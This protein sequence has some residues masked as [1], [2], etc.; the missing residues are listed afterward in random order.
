MNRAFILL[1]M[2]LL[3]AALHA[4]PE[5]VPDSEVYGDA[6]P[7]ASALPLSRAVSLLDTEEALVDQKITGKITE[8]CQ[9]KGCWMVLQDDGVSARVT[10]RDYGFFVPTLSQSR[11]CEVYG[12][13]K[14]KTLSAKQARHYEK[15]AGRKSDI[16]SPQE[17]LTIVASSVRIYGK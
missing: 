1:M 14:R 2:T 10:F 9:K 11:S 8:V 17:E 12:E 3:P 7:E 6:M 5:D 15:D 4:A 16:S 13:L